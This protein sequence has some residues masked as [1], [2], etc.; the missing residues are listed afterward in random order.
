MRV[1]AIDLFCGAGGLTYGLRE[2]GINVLRGYDIDERCRYPFEANNPDSEFIEKDVSNITTDEISQAFEDEDISLLAGCA[3]CQ[4]FS[5]LTNGDNAEERDDWGLIND[6][7]ELIDPNMFLPDII[8]MENVPD[9][10]KHQVY[11][12]FESHLKES[13]YNIWSEKIY[14]PKYGIP[15]SRK[16]WVLLASRHGSIELI[17]PIYSDEK[18]YPTVRD[19]IGGRNRQ[20]SIK[21]G[22]S[23]EDDP[24]HR[25]RGLSEKNKKRMRVS[26]PGK[27]WELW[28][29]KGHDNLLLKC[30]K[31]ASGQSYKSPYGIMEWDKVGPTITT[32]FYNYGSGRFG[33]PDEEEIRAISLREGAMLQ[34]FPENY[35]FVEEEDDLSMKAVGQF[36]GNAVPPRLGEAI[37]K[38]I[39]EHTSKLDLDKF[40][41]PA[42]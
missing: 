33:H 8:T 38:S 5:P 1:S 24:M 30:H 34:T 16:R 21:A 18:D 25:S 42:K 39:I 2:A 13:G 32:Q 28:R 20:P 17:D 36:I 10:K 19:G 14:C 7:A 9:V 4:P 26:E 3:P 40:P 35:E 6:F 29:E 23:H 37:G 22:Q 27:T 12:D 11:S 15:Q 41:K 31:K